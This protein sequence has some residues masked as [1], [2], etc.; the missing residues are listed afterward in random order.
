MTELPDFNA[1]TFTD[2]T[3]VDNPYFPLPGGTVNSYEAV[4]IDPESGEEEVERNDHFATYET[5]DIEG[6][7]VVVVRDTAYADGFLDEDTLDWF[8]QD[9]DGNVWYMGEI[10]VNYNY[11]DDDN[12]IGTDFDGSWEAGVDGALPGYLMKAAPMLGDMYFQEFYAGVAED[13]GEVIGVGQMIAGFNDVLSIFDTSALEPESGAIKHFAPGIGMVLEEEFDLT[14]PEEPELV[15][16]LT[17]IINADNSMPIDP[18]DLAFA[19]DGTEMTVTFLTEDA[20]VN[21]AIGAYSFDNATGEIGEG[22]ILFEDTEDVV[23]G[24][25]STI[26]VPAGQ[27]LGL[28]L[29][30]DVEELG[31]DLED[32]LEGGLYFGNL[33]LGD[34]ADVYDGDA[35]TTYT[36]GPATIFDGVAPVV[37]DAEGNMLPIRAFHSVGNR[38]GFNFLN[39]VAGEN[40]LESGAG[41][42][43]D[44]ATVISFEDGLASTEDYDGDFDDAFVAVSAAPLTEDDLETLLDEIDISRLV[45]TDG[46]N[47]LRGTE[48]D[49]QLIG[50]DSKDRLFGRDGDDII[51]AGDGNDFVRGGAGDDEIS[52][53]DG[54]DHLRGGDG[55]DEIEGGEGIDHLFGERGDDVLYGDEGNDHLFGGP[56]Y[57]S[58]FGG[59][60]DDRLVAKEDGA[61]MSGGEGN[62]RLF[63]EIGAADTFVF[64]LIPF[65]NDRI[66]RFE[67][68][69]DLIEI[70]TYLEV[71]EFADIDVA[72]AGSS[73]VLSFA[74]GT[75]KLVGIDAALI[76]ASDFVFV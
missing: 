30:P 74:D 66:K 36:P 6:V 3:A 32:Y 33:T 62:D 14:A 71:E 67:D 63:G 59:E 53:E 57:D 51:E 11:D 16:E 19:G 29:I 65:G 9:D 8:A 15:I 10:A 54:I 25:T 43:V 20:N 38:D 76:D 5:K 2:P 69:T 55:A 1:A 46:R 41:D 31:I 42:L 58:L 60:G 44:S 23:S 47:R 24:T 52:G 39:H 35:N 26:T 70:A 7:T 45:G 18:T 22:R 64:D 75:V 17:G 12:F 49:D 4:A 73:T 13:E 50:L 48:D 68:G 72:Q 21:G 27:S 37:M 61:R 56:G 34:V 28:F 40:A